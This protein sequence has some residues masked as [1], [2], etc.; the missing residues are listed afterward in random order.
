MLSVLNLWTQVLA[1]V[2]V[3]VVLKIWSIA[4]VNLQLS[5]TEHREKFYC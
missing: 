5:K 1:V 4:V 3:I 2:V